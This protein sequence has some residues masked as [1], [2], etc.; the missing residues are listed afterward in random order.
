MLS[1]SFFI[2]E[3]AILHLLYYTICFAQHSC[4]ELMGDQIQH[5]FIIA[6]FKQEIL[7]LFNFL[8]LPYFF[9]SSEECCYCLIFV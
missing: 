8:R 2:D 6:G 7:F 3:C 1:F 5:I 9:L 4:F